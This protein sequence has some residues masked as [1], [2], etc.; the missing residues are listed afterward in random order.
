MVCS[1]AVIHIDVCAVVG[2][3]CEIGKTYCELTG[4]AACLNGATCQN[5]DGGY[6]CHCAPGYRGQ[7][8]VC[9]VKLTSTLN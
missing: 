6:V 3:N 9:S 4:N 5:M 8:S 2:R 1:C 7:F